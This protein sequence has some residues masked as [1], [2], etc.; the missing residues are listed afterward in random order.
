MLYGNQ[1]SINIMA[2]FRMMLLISSIRYVICNIIINSI[3]FFQHAAVNNLNGI[4]FNTKKMENV[5]ADYFCLH[6]IYLKNGTCFNFL[7]TNNTND[8]SHK[9]IS[10]ARYESLTTK[11][12]VPTRM[13]SKYFP[14]FFFIC[15]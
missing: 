1:E 14:L 3:S 4:Y 8:L 11:W 5:M 6:P 9:I 15:I 7:P 2:L 12:R 13:C 10:L